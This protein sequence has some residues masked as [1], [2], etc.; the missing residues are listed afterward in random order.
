[1]SQRKIALV[2]LTAVFQAQCHI[3]RRIYLKH[4]LPRRHQANAYV[5]GMPTFRRLK[6]VINSVHQPCS[7]A[8]EET[9]RAPQ[10]FVAM[11]RPNP[12]SHAVSS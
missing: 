6:V 8:A 9:P 12:W 10:S 7:S 1:M 5:R 11:E 3:S 4:D 2:A